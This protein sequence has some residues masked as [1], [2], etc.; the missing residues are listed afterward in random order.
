MHRCARSSSTLPPLLIVWQLQEVQ[1]GLLRIPWERIEAVTPATLEPAADDPVWRRWQRPLRPTEMALL[2]S[3]CRAWRRAL[4]LAE[5]CLVLEDD[6]LLAATA[7]AFLDRVSDLSG[8]DHISLE[9]RGRK[10]TVGRR[11]DPRAPMRRLWQDRTGSAA[12]IVWPAGAHL[13]LEHCRREGGPSDAIISSTYTL[14]SYQADPAL[15][16]QLDQCAGLWHR[17]AAGDRVVRGRHEKAAGRR[18]R[19]L[20]PSS[21]SGSQGFRRLVAQLTIGSRRWMRPH[22][23]ERR[24][25]A[26]GG[27][28]PPELGTPSQAARS[29]AR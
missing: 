6:A 10:K 1:L 20:G 28:I 16:V 3:H 26:P 19:V 11:P 29:E 18:G 23:T 22:L 13:L 15:A 21:A 9:T 27:G 8:I 24:A 14:R 2:A 12:Y 4:A 25:A 5:A 7:P 17:P